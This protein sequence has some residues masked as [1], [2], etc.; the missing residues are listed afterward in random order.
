[1]TRFPDLPAFSRIWAERD[2]GAED[3]GR[4]DGVTEE[5]P[6]FRGLR[7]TLEAG[8]ELLVLLVLLVLLAVE[9]AVMLLVSQIHPP[10]DPGALRQAIDR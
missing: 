7:E 3:A 4:E 1:M 8:E 9:H 5:L 2:F 10:D 6:E